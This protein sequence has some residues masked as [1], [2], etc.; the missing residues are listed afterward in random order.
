MSLARHLLRATGVGL[1][2]LAVGLMLAIRLAPMRVERWHVDPTSAQKQPLGN[3][4]VLR[5]F[6]VAQDGAD[7]I[8]WVYDGD[9]G[10]LALRLQQTALA[11]PRTTLLAGDAAQGF[12]TLVQRSKWMGFPD[13]ISIRTSDL[14]QGRATLAIWSRPRYGNK[15]WGVNR[16]RVQRW[17]AANRSFQVDPRPLPAASP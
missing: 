13:A 5:P 10:S 15:D 6:G 8:A 9:V 3:D 11:E 1:A 7:G 2:V 17:L 4:Y 12:I 16:A 14:G